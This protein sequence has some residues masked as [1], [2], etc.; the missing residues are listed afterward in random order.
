[1]AIEIDWE[2]ATEIGR[3]RRRNEDA[4]GVTPIAGGSGGWLLAIA[5]GMGGHARGDVASKL[6]LDA[7]VAAAGRPEAGGADRE[8]LLR[9]IFRD[10]HDA[11][12]ERAIREPALQAMGTTLTVLLLRDDGAWVGHAGDT[13]LLWW[14]EGTVGI[15]TRDHSA[16]WDLVEKGLLS[17]DD[18]EREPSGAVLTRYLGAAAPPEPDVFD[19]S[20]DLLAGD[21]LLL[22]TDGLGK[23]VSMDEVAKVL[24]GRSVKAAASELIERTLRGGAP[25]NASVIVADV[26][27]P[28]PLPPHPRADIPALRFEELRFRWPAAR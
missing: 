27:V 8:G 20:L 28:P 1:M 14:R 16:A 12:R 25:D 24:S 6:A 22:C 5:D 11:L 17:P 18:A 26:T 2:G 15:V 9:G 3:I 19:R 7:A 4:W 23:V 13:R 10:A 21:R